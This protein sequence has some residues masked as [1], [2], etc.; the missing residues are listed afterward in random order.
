MFLLRKKTQGFKTFAFLNLAL[1]LCLVNR[2]CPFKLKMEEVGGGGL[3]FTLSPTDSEK[4]TP[5]TKYS[6][7]MCQF[8]ENYR[9]L[10]STI[11]VCVR[12]E[13]RRWLKL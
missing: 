5:T 9:K 10:I 2:M 12:G 11:C 3:A 13:V 7:K 6:P 8:C 4:C 1:K